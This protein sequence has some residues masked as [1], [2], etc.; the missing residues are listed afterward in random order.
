M[1]QTSLRVI[2]LFIFGFRRAFCGWKYFYN[3]QKRWICPADCRYFIL[4]HDRNGLV[5]ILA[6][7][8]SLQSLVPRSSFETQQSGNT[9][10]YDRYEK[11]AGARV[12]RRVKMSRFYEATFGS[13]RVL[14]LH[15]Y[16]Y[17]YERPTLC[18]VWYR[19]ELIRLGFMGDTDNITR[20]TVRPWPRRSTVRPTLE[21]VK[22][23]IINV[24]IC[25]SCI[26]GANNRHSQKTWSQQIADVSEANFY[27]L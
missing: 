14:R 22:W 19:N 13:Y 23:W 15:D 12:R 9:A 11:Y 20:G 4:V 16:V 6:N 10:T 1:T 27:I 18:N 8:L 26:D 17:D 24:I 2:A 21:A 5:Y 3:T 25:F 7:V